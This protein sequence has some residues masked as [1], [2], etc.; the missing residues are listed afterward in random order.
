M[1]TWTMVLIVPTA[2][3]IVQFYATARGAKE[4]TVRGGR[5]TTTIPRE[6]WLAFALESASVQCSRAITGSN[7]PGTAGEVLISLPTSWPESW[8][9]D[10]LTLPA[11][12]AVTWPLFCLPAWWF[13]G[14]GLDG[15]LGGRRLHWVSLVTGSILCVFFAV[16]F[17]GLRVT[18]EAN[19]RA[20]P[21]VFCG[22]GFWA[23]A[24]GLP[25]FAW[26]KQWRRKRSARMSQAVADR[27]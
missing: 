9:P 24:F 5:Y 14:R 13:V 20:D 11:W 1:A 6:R 23:V 8:H 22:L 17:I 12:R 26:V 21:W 16:L 19:D 15:L 27:Q 7:I 18:L 4:I 25:P 2:A 3:T 10:G